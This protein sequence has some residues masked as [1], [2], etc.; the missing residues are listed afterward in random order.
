M[1][2]Q[3]MTLAN[4]KGETRDLSWSLPDGVPKNTLPDARIEVLNSK[5]EHKVF[6][7]F[8]GGLINPWGAGEQSKYIDDPFAGPWN[9][10]PM[11]LVP[12]DGRFAVATDRVTHFALGANDAAPKFGSMVLY[13]FTRQPVASLVPLARS[14]NPPPEIT[15]LAGCK[16]AGY[17]KETRDYPLVAEKETMSV[18]IAA[19][20]ESPLVNPC[21]TVRNWGH[22]GAAQVKTT[23]S[24]SEGCPP[25]NHRRYRRHKNHGHLARIWPPHQPLPSTSAAQSHRP[26][27]HLNPRETG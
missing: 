15:A 24:R 6:A 8:Q 3:A 25:G 2:L 18:R 1:N 13:G 14:W 27:M 21:F 17:R 22:H 10:W 19:T 9:H 16:A 11:H 5:S 4:L 12:S 7:M 26:M 20:E 23:A